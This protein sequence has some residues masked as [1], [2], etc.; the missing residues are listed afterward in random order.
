ME[1]LKNILSVPKQNNFSCWQK[2]HIHFKAIVLLLYLLIHICKRLLDFEEKARLCICYR[3]KK[4][5]G[6][7]QS[8]Q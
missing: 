2:I 3:R 1:S 7:V 8:K 4:D 5:V 6:V